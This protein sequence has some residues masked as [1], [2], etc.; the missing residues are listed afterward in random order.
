MQD[1]AETPPILREIAQIWVDA[2]SMSL[3]PVSY[4][5]LA[6]RMERMSRDQAKAGHDYY[7]AVSLH[8]A[9]IAETASGK[10]TEAIRLSEAAL[11]VYDR[12][13]FPAAEQYSTHALL[14]GCWL[15]LGV[16]QRA[17][18]HIDLSLKT[19]A[20]HADVH[21]D[22]AYLSALIGRR[23]RAE[24]LLVSAADLV[25]QGFS[26]IHARS[27]AILVRVL[28]RLGDDAAGAL[29][30]LRELPSERPMDVGATLAQ[31]TLRVAGLFLLDR[32]EEAAAAAQQGLARAIGH[33]GRAAAVR[34]AVLEALAK[35]DPAALSTAVFEARSV[36]NLALLELA[37]AIGHRLDLVPDAP[38]IVESVERWPAR[39]LPVLRRQLARGPSPAARA[40]GALLDR[41]GTIEDV[42]RLRAYAKTY[43]ARSRQTAALGKA[44]ARRVSPRLQLEDLGRVT[45]RVGDRVISLSRA[46]RKCASLLMFLATRP[47]L[48]ATRELVLDELWPDSEPQTAANSLNQTLYFL[49]RELDPWY[50]DDMSVEY[51]LYQGELIWLDPDLV[52]IGSVGFLEAIRQ[53]QGAAFDRDRAMELIEAY[54]GPFA[55]EFEYEE[56]AMAW[57][58]KVHASFLEFANR[59][60]DRLIDDAE[61]GKARD[62][63]IAAF[64]VDPSALD[65][66]VKLIW[67]YWHL[68]ARSAAAAQYRHF[69][70]EEAADGL[71]P[72]TLT[73]LVGGIRPPT[74]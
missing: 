50:E 68:G 21:V 71:D 32:S 58:T 18:E 24:Q 35:E 22:L 5:E 64:E 2:S 19:R 7:A 34:L 27:L 16:Q 15:E 31:E 1:D 51:V 9:A 54:V 10:F 66:E 59:T 36:G 38:E 20:E 70:S 60:I 28:M 26:D 39:W 57:R 74:E 17:E 47:N 56:W 29:V 46:R 45:V 42:V 62:A 37:D 6:R 25:R 67:I 48:T 65:V 53:Q 3:S 8:N 30:V 49:R 63:A 69:A 72:P 73:A 44:L 14:A 13:R 61:L 40:A 41:F 11:A 52:T 4:P 43:G 33:S 23:D 12:L 55:P